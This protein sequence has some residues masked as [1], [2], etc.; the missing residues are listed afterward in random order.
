M[1]L[2][3]V[4]LSI[5]NI[6]ACKTIINSL[7]IHRYLLPLWFPLNLFNIQGLVTKNINCGIVLHTIEMDSRSVYIYKSVYIRCR[8]EYSFSN[9]KMLPFS[10]GIIYWHIRK[11]LRLKISMSFPFCIFSTRIADYGEYINCTNISSKRRHLNFSFAFFFQRCKLNL[12]CIF[13]Q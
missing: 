10:F 8:F 13:M 9:C 6:G 2:Y 3:L 1:F 5:S 4:H 12:S 11:L 7:H